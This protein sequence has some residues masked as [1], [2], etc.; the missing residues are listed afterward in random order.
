MALL[1]SLSS[2]I[3]DAF[4]VENITQ[5][6]QAKRTEKALRSAASD[7]GTSDISNI[8]TGVSVP[9]TFAS[10]TGNNISNKDSSSS[11]TASDSQSKD[12][13]NSNTNTQSVTA[14]SISMAP[15]PGSASTIE[16]FVDKKS[17]KSKTQLWQELKIECK[18]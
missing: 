15:A 4:P 13:Q 14:S 1:P 7:A 6:L 16:V 3:I 12:T 11:T 9:T 8:T 2:D 17:R 18:F 10:S 5:E